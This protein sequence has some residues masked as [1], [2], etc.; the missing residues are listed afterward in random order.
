[1]TTPANAAEHTLPV[2]FPLR[3]TGPCGPRVRC[4]RATCRARFGEYATV[5]LLRDGTRL[6]R[7]HGITYHRGDLVERL[8]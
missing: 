8:P 5:E 7:C 2:Q 6:A 1:M 3:H 4:H